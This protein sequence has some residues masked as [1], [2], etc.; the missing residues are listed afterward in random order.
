MR[1]LYGEGLP[2]PR[3]YTISDGQDGRALL[4]AHVSDRPADALW[5]GKADAR[6]E[7]E[8]AA[9]VEQLAALLAS[10]H[11]LQPPL[12]VREVL[13]QVTVAEQMVRLMGIGRRCQD[14]GIV[15][16]VR[17]LALEKVEERPPCV[18][19]GDPRFG[20]VRHDARG[21]TAMLNWE[22]SVQGD[23][24]WDVARVVVWLRYHHTPD[25]A[26][27]FCQVYGERSDAPLAG[28]A[29]W[30]TAAAVQQWAVG[31]STLAEQSALQE[32]V[33]LWGE[34]AWRGLTRWRATR[35]P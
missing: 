24:R 20:S 7:A 28:I 5:D 14:E 12:A 22:S 18:V 30:E 8:R 15:E 10:L 31:L 26:D 34:H 35:S 33:A 19:H 2:V 23:P 29:Y 3:L 17:E 25:L 6:A 13:P 21:I 32:Q 11:R 4:A 16:A 9:R 27:R 1:W